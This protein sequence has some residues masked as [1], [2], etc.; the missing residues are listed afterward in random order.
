M[1]YIFYKVTVPESNKAVTLTEFLK[2]ETS[3]YIK[4]NEFSDV[5][6]SINPRFCCIYINEDSLNFILLVLYPP[7][8]IINFLLLEFLMI[9]NILFKEIY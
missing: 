8:G 6:S 3:G 1:T 2:F 9:Q 7:N 5:I 4:L